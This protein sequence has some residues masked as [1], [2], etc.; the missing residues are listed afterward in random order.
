MILL[1]P[2]GTPLLYAVLL[3]QSREAL[4]KGEK[5]PLSRAIAFLAEGYGAHEFWWELVRCL[6]FSESMPSRASS[7]RLRLLIYRRH[8]VGCRYTYALLFLPQVE[9]NRKLALSIKS[10]RSISRHQHCRS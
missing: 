7:S 10:Y 8:P 4:V 3:W 9:M 6:P 5:T 2:V 1:W